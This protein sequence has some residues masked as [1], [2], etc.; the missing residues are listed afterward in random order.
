MELKLIYI[1]LN[2]QL[3]AM[4]MA[5]T[6]VFCVHTSLNSQESSFFKCLNDKNENLLVI[7]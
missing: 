1:R 4:T 2:H 3:V 7:Q 5:V 6:F